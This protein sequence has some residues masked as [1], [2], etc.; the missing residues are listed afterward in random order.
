M[1][2]SNII[3]IILLA[4][5]FVAIV[6]SNLVLKAEYEK[7]DRKDPLAGYKKEVLKPF[8]YIKLQGKAFGLTEIRQ[9]A[10][11]EIDM[12]S[13]PKHL[14]W[15]VKDDTLFV[16]YKR[17]WD[18]Q[19]LNRDD[20]LKSVASIYIFSPQLLQITSDNVLCRVKGWKSEKLAI[21]QNG[22]L[23]TFTDNQ[24]SNL[25]LKLKAGN[26]T[27]INEL[28]V[29][30]KAN[31]EVADSSSLVIEKDNMKAMTARFDSA[32]HLT[33]PGSLFRKISVGK[34]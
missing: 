16:N 8:K 11:Y 5:V 4:M 9:G 18:E 27:H 6:G 17:T 10:N 7:L 32:T 14:S 20:K 1:K 29:F 23:L 21:D 12:N 31:V 13:N 33:M 19:W 25:D 2:A 24:I 26:Y 30:G 15:E 22:S 34:E 28:N 3:T